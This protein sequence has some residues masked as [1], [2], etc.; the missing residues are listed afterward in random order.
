V[1]DCD[2]TGVPPV[3]PAGDADVSVRVWVPVESHAVHAEYVNDVHV[4]GV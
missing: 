2:S 1:H 3:Q 4:G